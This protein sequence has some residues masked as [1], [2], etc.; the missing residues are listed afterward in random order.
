MIA[1]EAEE[2]VNDAENVV[3][4]KVKEVAKAEKKVE[5]ATP[6]TKPIKVA[7]AK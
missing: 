4:K 7:V 5:E 3:E 6:D 1:N 2:K